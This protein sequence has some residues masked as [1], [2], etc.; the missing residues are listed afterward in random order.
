MNKRGR[1][2][3]SGKEG[4]GVE[5]TRVLF[6]SAGFQLPG[7][8]SNLAETTLSAL[9]QLVAKGRLASVDAVSLLDGDSTKTRTPT[10]VN[11]CNGSKPRFVRELGRRAYASDVIIFD[12]VG[13]ARA[14][15]LLPWCRTPVA[16]FV[17]GIEVDRPIRKTLIRPLKQ[18]TCLLCVSPT[19]LK[20]VRENVARSSG[21]SIVLAPGISPDR[22]QLWSGVE[23]RKTPGIVLAVGRIDPRQPG[24]GFDTLVRSMMAVNSRVPGAQLWIVGEGEGLGSLRSLSIDLEI[25]DRVRFLGRVSDRDLGEIYRTASVFAMPSRQEGFG[26]VY[27]E[28]MW[29]GLPCLGSVADAASDVIQHG[30]TG[31]L[32]PFGDAEATA[33]ALVRLLGDPEYSDRLG[34]NGQLLA[35]ERYSPAAYESR[36]AEAIACLLPERSGR[37]KQGK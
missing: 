5:G 16:T 8:I 32:V 34:R 14:M 11:A 22:I 4:G 12:S 35:R 37:S 31:L 29:H 2:G 24:K 3:W 6:A 27:A 36:L 9:N 33:E 28:A 1:N 30:R 21:G 18:A 23:S 20:K 7:G 13:P 25:A 19:T 15:S 26:L 10:S 17:H